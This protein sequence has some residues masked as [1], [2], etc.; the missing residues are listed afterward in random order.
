MENKDWKKQF[1]EEYCNFEISERI[2]K[3]T[4]YQTFMI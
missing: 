3:S 2:S 1:E 4:H